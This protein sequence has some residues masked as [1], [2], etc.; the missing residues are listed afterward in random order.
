MAQRAR[1]SQIP[2]NALESLLQACYTRPASHCLLRRQAHPVRSFSAK[3][4][5]PNPDIPDVAIIGGGIT[6]LSTAYYLSRALPEST[7]I[8]LFEA[9]H[10]LGGWLNSTSVDVDNGK[11]IFEGGPRTLRPSVP[12]GLIT[13]DLV[14]FVSLLFYVFYISA[15]FQAR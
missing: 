8:V 11:V 12:N 10:R 14:G 5:A 4:I 2:A 15:P 13:L 3:P 7:R 1:T 9:S 6:G